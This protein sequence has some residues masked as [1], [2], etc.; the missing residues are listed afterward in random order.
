MGE[1]EIKTQ[2]NELKEK[3]TELELRLFDMEDSLHAKQNYEPKI[4]EKERELLQK[5]D[6]ELVDEIVQFFKKEGFNFAADWEIWSF[7]DNYLKTLGLRDQI[8]YLTAELQLK[9]HRVRF[10]LE[11]RVKEIGVEEK[12]KAFEQDLILAKS[13]IN[14]CVE[15]A[16]KNNFSKV[17][18]EDLR[19]FLEV[20]L[21]KSLS[22]EAFRW[23]WNQVNFELRR[24][25]YVF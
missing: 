22:H 11:K 14:D 2:L 16:K 23:L 6:E 9:L 21:Q 25:K 13:L 24:S 10:L 5:T 3:I 19:L 18:Q 15:W 12:R 7:Y 8:H 1:D 4:I 20:K 17:V